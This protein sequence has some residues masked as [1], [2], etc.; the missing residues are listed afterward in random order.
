MGI[1]MIIKSSLTNEQLIAEIYKAAAE[2]EKLLNK[3]FLII[4]KNKTS[5]YFW[6]ECFFEKKHFMHLLG[7]KSKT[8]SST[9]FFDICSSHNRGEDVALNIWDCTAR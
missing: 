6:F 1:Q 5:D 2:Y 3:K 4:G 8:L 9:D 7:I